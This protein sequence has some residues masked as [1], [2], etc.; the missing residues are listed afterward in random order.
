MKTLKTKNQTKII[1]HNELSFSQ[2][3]LIENLVNQFFVFDTLI[4]SRVAGL[5]SVLLT[6]QV[7]DQT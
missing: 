1:Y 5:S 7:L 3:T 4:E 6:S 2:I